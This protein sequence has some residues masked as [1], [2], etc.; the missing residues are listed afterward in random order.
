M[1][2]VKALVAEEGCLRDEMVAFQ[3]AVICPLCQGFA[4]VP[5]TDPLAEELK[6]SM[7][8]TDSP[9]VPDMASGLGGLALRI[10]DS[11]AVAYISTE[12]FGGLGG[13]DAVA[14]S[15]GEVI[16]SPENEGYDG[17]WPNS[18]ISQAL[19]AIGVIANNGQD[20]FDTLGL[21]RHRETH[22]WAEAFASK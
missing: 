13:Q 8:G 17:T 6:L 10:S 22:R 5:I 3:N 9:L 19:K 4:L 20:E 16:F 2:D 14:W 11:V 15:K 7:R 18:A 12:Y 1:H 21:G